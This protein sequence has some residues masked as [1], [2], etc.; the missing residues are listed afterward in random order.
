M[1][2]LFGLPGKTTA[3]AHSSSAKLKLGFNSSVFETGPE[4]YAGGPVVDATDEA[5][6][7]RYLSPILNDHGDIELVGMCWDPDC[8]TWESSK[9]LLKDIISD[10]SYADQYSAL[11]AYV[12]KVTKEN[13]AKDCAIH[14]FCAASGVLSKP[15]VIK[16]FTY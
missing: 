5:R 12:E 1:Q 13:L 2:N 10:C 7:L 3:L 4:F 9:V 15:L 6:A 16:G 14:N 8:S 11:K